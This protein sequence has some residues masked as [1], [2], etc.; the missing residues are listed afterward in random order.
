M[1]MLNQIPTA[2]CK[3]MPAWQT[4]QKLT[5]YI[6]K[7]AVHHFGTFQQGMPTGDIKIDSAAL[8]ME[9]SSTSRA[10]EVRHVAISFPDS[11][12]EKEALTRLPKMCED[13]IAKYAPDRAYRRAKH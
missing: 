7:K 6:Y 9:H 5:K 11:V 8:K 2:I 13:W 12:K 1:S 4:S 10:C 3:L